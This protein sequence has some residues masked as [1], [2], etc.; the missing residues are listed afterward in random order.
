[1]AFL[2]SVFLLFTYC[3]SFPLALSFKQRVIVIIFLLLFFSFFFSL[4]LLPMLV[5]N[6][7]QGA[8]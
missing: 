3:L 5:S 8:Q 6:R 4:F 7:R 2:I 1:M